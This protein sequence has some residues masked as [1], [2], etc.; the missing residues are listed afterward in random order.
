MRVKV[1][2]HEGQPSTRPRFKSN[3]K[4]WRMGQ[5]QKSD[6]QNVVLGH[7]F[8]TVPFGYVTLTSLH[9]GGKNLFSGDL[10]YTSRQYSEEQLTHSPVRGSDGSKLANW[11]VER[12]T[13]CRWLSGQSPKSYW[14]K[15]IEWVVAAINYIVIGNGLAARSTSQSWMVAVLMIPIIIITI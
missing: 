2:P 10:Y 15:S 6:P 12:R 8:K 3:L 5:P 11:R 14:L 1:L 13:N 9:G 7:F 4:L